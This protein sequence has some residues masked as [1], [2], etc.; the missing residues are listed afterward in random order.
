MRSEGED[1]ARKR[2]Y[3][4]ITDERK[5]QTNEVQLQKREKKKINFINFTEKLHLIA[6][7]YFLLSS[8]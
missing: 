8:F 3:S 5:I 2:I 1:D 7:F 6:F 4:R